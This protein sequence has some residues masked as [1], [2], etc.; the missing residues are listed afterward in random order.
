MLIS[1]D[2]RDLPYTIDTYG[3]FTGDS[4]YENEIDFLD[5][6]YPELREDYPD[7]EVHFNWNHSQIVKGLAGWSTAIIEHEIKGEKWLL[8]LPIIKTTGS[9]REYNFTADW[10]VADWNIDVAELDKVV[11]KDWREQAKERGWTDDDLEDE[12]SVIVAKMTARMLEL[13]TEDE[14][15]SQMWE[16]EGEVYCENMEPDE[17]T[18][19]AIDEINDKREKKD[20]SNN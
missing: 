6:E 7:L 20:V 13:L 8:S 17:E 3:M 11:P 15:H 1:I 9:P 5:S 18:Q 16:H 4:Q 14:Y 12:E 19:K 10:Y 2:N